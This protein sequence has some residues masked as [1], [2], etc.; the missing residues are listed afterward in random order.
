MNGRPFLV[1]N[2]HEHSMGDSIFRYLDIKIHDDIKTA[3]YRQIQVIG[4]Y[5]RSSRIFK[6][7]KNDKLENWQRPTTR[8]NSD[9]LIVQCFPGKDYV[10]HY[11]SL[12]ASYL[13]LTGRNSSIVSYELPSDDACWQPIITSRLAELRPT[14][15]LLLGAGLQQI[16][17]PDR[18]NDMGTFHL[19]KTKI[20]NKTATLLLIKHSFWGDIAG[21]LLTHLA[22]LGF[23]NVIF[24]GKLGSLR[25]EHIPNEYLATGDQT[26]VEGEFVRWDN[27]FE[28]IEDDAL[29]RGTH[30]TLPSVL[31]ETKQWVE[32]EG[33]RYDFVDPEIGHLAK[34]AERS[35]IRFSYLHLISDNL[36]RRYSEDLSNEREEFVLLK[37]AKLFKKIRQ[38]LHAVL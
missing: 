5:D 11:A 31:L 37:R 4:Y 6:N 38:H 8:L 19:K 12:I 1:G 20:N 23:T 3:V 13:A 32:E 27:I 24:I 25:D 28:R 15:V 26:F 33:I 2:P 34:A 14:D 29:C 18:W 16:A 30:I 7:E 22:G 17:G 35:L 9:T 36:V 21:R 10:Q